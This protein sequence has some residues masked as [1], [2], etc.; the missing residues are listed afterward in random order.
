MKTLLLLV[1]EDP[2]QEARL[3]AALDLARAL[4]GHLKCVDVTPL[5][6][7]LGDADG[8]AQ[9]LILMDER[10][11]ETANRTL[12][13]ARLA[14]EEVPW[15]W[16]D[17]IGDMAG[18]VLREAGLADLIVIN[19]KR[20]TFL[21]ID[22]RGISST[23]ADQARCPVIA[24]PD[25]ARGLDANGPVVIAWDG[26]GPVMATLRASTPLLKLATSVH[27]LHV[28]EGSEPAEGV[29]PEAAAAYLSR[30]GIHAV[31]ERV[32]AQQQRPDPL[33]LEACAARR[34]RYCLMGAYGKGRLREELFGGVTRRLLDAAQLPLL[35]GH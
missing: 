28:Q 35:L 27:I 1:H 20:D 2:G 31:I 23:L 9:G 18:C 14:G 19:C 15:D 5:P 21:A 24:V 32:T 8:T 29:P 30:Y 6:L 12:L 7:F 34:A 33:I 25:E 17:S 10:E 4:E 13:E 16:I 22:P 11:T 3:Q 26:G